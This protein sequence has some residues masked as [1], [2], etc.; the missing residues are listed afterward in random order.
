MATDNVTL[1]AR[2]EELIRDLLDEDDLTVIDAMR[3]F[4]KSFRE[5]ARKG[6]ADCVT[7]E[8]FMNDLRESLTEMFRAQ[9]NGV[10][11]KTLR[12][13]IDEL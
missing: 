1:Y 4:L 10:K 2:R 7:K 3:D 12:E 5:K 13:A 11:R 8:E 6:E 9:R